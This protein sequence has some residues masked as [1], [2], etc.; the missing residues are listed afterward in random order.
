MIRA[1][2]RVYGEEP[3]LRYGEYREMVLTN[4]AY[5]F[6]R[7]DVLVTVNCADGPADFDLPGNGLYRGSLMG[8]EAWEQGERIHV[9]IPGN[10]GEIWIPQ[11]PGRERCVPAEPV[12]TESVKAEAPA[13]A[14]AAPEE[15]G[16]R[17]IATDKNDSGSYKYDPA[18]D[19]TLQPG[20]VPEDHS[21]DTWKVILIVGLGVLGVAAAFAAYFFILTL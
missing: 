16:F 3:A 1:L 9:R 15:E 7:G 12:K 20:Y 5:A 10:S 18:R 21:G 14:K 2:G 19:R 11:Q 13:A 17:Y 4:T 8:Q 6:A